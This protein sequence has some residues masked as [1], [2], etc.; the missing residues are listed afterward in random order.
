MFFEMHVFEQSLTGLI[1]KT[2]KKNQKNHIYRKL[3][4]FVVFCDG[5]DNCLTRITNIS[6]RKDKEYGKRALLRHFSKWLLLNVEPPVLSEV[7]AYMDNIAMAVKEPNTSGHTTVKVITLLWEPNS[8]KWSQ[9][10]HLMNNGD[11]CPSFNASLFPNSAFK[12]NGRKLK[13]G[14]LEWGPFCTKSTWRKNGS[15]TYNGVCKDLFDSLAECLNFTYELMEPPDQSWG[16]FSGTWTGLL[17]MVARND[18]DLAGVPYGITL[19]RSESFTFPHIMYQSECEVAHKKLSNVDNSWMLLLSCFKME[20]YV[21]GFLT[22]AWCIGLYI[23]MKRLSVVEFVKAREM[24]TCPATS[25]DF[26]TAVGVPL[27]QGSLHPPQH[28]PGRFLYASWWL[29]CII[30]V[31]VYKGNLVAILSVV[32]ENIPFNT[33]D[34]LAENDD[35]KILI[36]KGSFQEDMYMHSNDSVSKKIWRKV[37]ESR[38]AKILN[39]LDEDQHYKMLLQ[40]GYY[41]YIA[42]SNTIDGIEKSVDNLRRMKCSAGPNY[43]SLPFPANSPLA[44]LFSDKIRLLYEKG[45]LEEWARKWSLR[46]P[47]ESVH[48]KMKVRISDMLSALI[49]CATGI[50]VAFITLGMERLLTSSMKK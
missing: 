50:T 39:S 20:V 25:E 22:M 2:M 16:E 26:M 37:L 18:I 45:L 29:F 30:I 21:C 24:S 9:I 36:S 28:T 10:G 14:I 7:H 6:S 31:A 49:M 4:N 34:E 44:E 41:A 8:R 40:S 12:L 15:I 46:K 38:S 33:I 48:A 47:D 1:Q 3:F 17:G 13:V 5:V 43:L 19:K 11:I 35:F 23:V 27:H 42:S 32:E